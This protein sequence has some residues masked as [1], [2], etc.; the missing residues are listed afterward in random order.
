MLPQ[1]SRL[2]ALASSL[3][4]LGRREWTDVVHSFFLVAAS[5]EQPQPAI[6]EIGGHKYTGADILLLASRSGTTLRKTLRRLV[7]KHGASRASCTDYM[8]IL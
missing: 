5:F 6:L 2:Y 1:A 8:M 3:A 4:E 7:K